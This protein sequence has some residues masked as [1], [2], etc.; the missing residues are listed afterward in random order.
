MSTFWTILTVC[1]IIVFVIVV[2][3]IIHAALLTSHEIVYVSYNEDTHMYVCRIK[4]WRNNYTVQVMDDYPF[5]TTSDG[6]RF[7]YYE[8]L[9]NMN[10]NKVKEWIR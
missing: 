1:V 9:K 7:V 4:G 8:L 3:F 5:S 6:E 2:G 10:K